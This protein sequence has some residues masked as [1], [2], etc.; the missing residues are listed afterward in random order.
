MA[1]VITDEIEQ[2][3]VNPKKAT[4]GG[5]TLEAHPLGDLIEADQHVQAKKAAKSKMRGLNL[6]KIS[7]PGGI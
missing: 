1:D 5:E 2:S 7:H 4:I 3:A 6:K